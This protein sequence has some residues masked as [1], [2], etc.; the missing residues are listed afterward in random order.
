MVPVF[1][2]VYCGNRRVASIPNSVHQNRTFTSAASL[3][4]CLESLLHSTRYIATEIRE[5][6]SGL[7]ICL[8][9]FCFGIQSATEKP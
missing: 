4:T 9:A 6:Y 7:L 5:Q 2:L 3:L 1:K 8:Y